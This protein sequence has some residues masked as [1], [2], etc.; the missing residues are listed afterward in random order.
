MRAI[1][2]D[3][4]TTGLL[5]PKRVP[6]ERQPKIIEVG[7]LLVDGEEVLDEFSQ[8]INPGETLPKI[9]T[10]ITGITD[11]DLFDEP[12]FDDVVTAIESM[13]EEAEALI[14][15]NA[16]F[17]KGMLKNELKRIE[18]NDFPWPE[19]TIC[20]V[21]EFMHVKGRRLKLTE[22]YE[23]FTGKPLAQTHRALDDCKAV[24]EALIAAGFFKEIGGENDPA[25][26]TN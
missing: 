14:C 10:K 15:H 21:Q 25:Q 4:E 12:P 17:D 20:T 16:N 5:K 13:F 11:D 9:I 7:V 3:T 22:L 26:D 23:H 1:I 8:L 18:A 19:K 24:H 2:F 6:L